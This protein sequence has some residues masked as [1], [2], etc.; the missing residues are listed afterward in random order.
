ML[1]IVDK[2]EIVACLPFTVV[3]NVSTELLVAYVLVITLPLPSCVALV[4]L[5]AVS[6]LVAPA[7]LL[8]VYARRFHGFH[9]L[10]HSARV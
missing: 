9:L 3:V 8:S 7:T 10:F 2:S 4:A 6:A 1:R 5:V